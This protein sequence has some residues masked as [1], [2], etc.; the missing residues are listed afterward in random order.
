MVALEA[1]TAD[2]NGT[3]DGD[4]KSGILESNRVTLESTADGTEGTM[5]V[6]GGGVCVACLGVLQDF[7]S[8][9]FAKKVRMLTCCD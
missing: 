2:K 9:E 3:E 6:G 1:A 7:C 4:N 8:P 5:G